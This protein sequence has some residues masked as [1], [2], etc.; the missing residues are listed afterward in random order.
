MAR[1]GLAEPCCS[2][3]QGAAPASPTCTEPPDSQGAGAAHPQP[4]QPPNPQQPRISPAGLTTRRGFFL[5]SVSCPSAKALLRVPTVASWE[6]E[7]L[8]SRA[9]LGALQGAQ[10]HAPGQG[11]ACWISITH[12]A[13]REGVFRA[14]R[15]GQ[16]GGSRSCWHNNLFSRDGSLQ[17][18]PPVADTERSVPGHKYSW[19]NKCWPGSAT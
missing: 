16:A 2:L 18:V 11:W 4:W 1:A 6:E 13:V 9:G 10:P 5:N 15:E 14:Q 3:M 12:P 17:G 19:Q 8:Q 7:S